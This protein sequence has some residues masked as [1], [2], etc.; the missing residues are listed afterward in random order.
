MGEIIHA[1]KR[2]RET[3]HAIRCWEEN[4]SFPQAYVAC[5]KSDVR[6]CPLTCLNHRISK[7]VSKETRFWKFR[8]KTN[9]IKQ[10]LTTAI[11]LKKFVPCPY[12]ILTSTVIR[13]GDY[14]PKNQ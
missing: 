6:Y 4:H 14:I 9:Y 1:Q 2:F 11:K 10:I 5:L 7:S 13:T 3:D 12:G 8:H